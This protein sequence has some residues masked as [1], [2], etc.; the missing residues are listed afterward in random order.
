MILSA[1]RVFAKSMMSCG[2]SASA[3]T[4][5][6]SSRGSATS[7]AAS[8]SSS[9]HGSPPWRVTIFSSGKNQHTSS[10]SA[11]VLRREADARP[12]HA[13]VHEDRDVELHALRVDRVH[14]LVVQ[15][16]LRDEARCPSSAPPW[17]RAP[18][19]AASSSRTASMPWFGSTLHRRRRTGRG[20]RCERAL[21]VAR[22][23]PTPVSALVM[24]CWSIFATSISTGSS[25][26]VVV[27]HALEHVLRGE[28][29]RP[30]CLGVVRLLADEVVDLALLLARRRE[31]RSS[32]R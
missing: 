32:C 27:R 28:L 25:T 2:C 30:G 12:G 8:P 22:R 6:S 5:W 31:R 24:P 20:T 11:D 4:R 9:V 1:P 13:R 7:T 10:S 17:R 15:R 16:H 19:T 14:L 18:R 26:V 23:R 29:P 3:R 21:G